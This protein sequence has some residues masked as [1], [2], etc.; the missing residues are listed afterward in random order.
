MEDVKLFE[1]K[2]TE[3]ERDIDLKKQYK[4]QHEKLLKDTLSLI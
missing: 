3:V 1:L 4:L 2:I